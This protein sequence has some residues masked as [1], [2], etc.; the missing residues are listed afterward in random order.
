MA[1]EVEYLLCKPEAMSSNPSTA[2][3]KKKKKT[4]SRFHIIVVKM[5]II[6]E[7]NN[8]DIEEKEHLYTFGGNVN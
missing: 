6:K 1:Q 5:A 8:K 7:T 3:K 2:K 4:T